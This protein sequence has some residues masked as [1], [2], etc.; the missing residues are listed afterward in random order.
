MGMVTYLPKSTF[1]RI[2]NQLRGERW[3]DVRELG[4]SN[5][6]AFCLKT[7][8]MWLRPLSSVLSE[9][10][11][12]WVVPARKHVPVYSNGRFLGWG[13]GI[14]VKESPRD[15]TII[16]ERDTEFEEVIVVDD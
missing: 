13:D 15:Y 2:V 16:Q 5:W 8:R 6:F 4:Y 11:L 9:E 14:K 7:G 10:G 1:L 3:N 12:G